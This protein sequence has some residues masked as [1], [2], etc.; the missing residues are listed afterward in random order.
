D[1]W[2]LR[3]L[4]IE[5]IE[6]DNLK[7]LTLGPF[8]IDAF[9]I[10]H[11][12]PDAVGLVIQT[13]VGQIVHLCDFKIDFQ[14]VA[15]KPA[16]LGRLVELTSKGTVLLMSDST[17][18]EMPGHTPSE[19]VIMKNLEEI[20]HNAPARI[21]VGTFASLLER[22]QQ[23]V[24][25][26]EEHDRKV[27]VE[28]Y[29][30]R[31]N[32]AIAQQLGYLKAK[33]GTI[34]TA[35][36]AGR[37]PANKLVILCTGAQ[38]EDRAVLMRIANK[39]HKHFRVDTGDTVI[40][41]SSIVPGNERAV[42][43]LKDSFYRQGAKV[44]HYKMMDIHASGHAHQE[45]LKLMINLVRP[46]YFMPIH[47]FHSMLRANQELA[48]EVG[49]PKENVI[50]ASNGGVV[51]VTTGKV[52]LAPQRVPAGYVMVD[53]LGIGDIGEVVLRDRQVM[54]QDGMVVIIG[55]IDTQ[56]GAL[57][58]EPDIISRGF[59][60][61]RESK[62]LVNEMKKRARFI[63]ERS[64]H[65]QRDINDLYIKN[66]LRDELGEF[67]FQKTKRRPMILPVLITV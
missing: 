31:S 64:I 29:S 25:I 16:D 6:K 59:V 63:I 23:I 35:E 47:G 13:P 1:F 8:A 49:I 32:V 39:E 9:H 58:G 7:T 46:K 65:G 66:N 26:A 38:G 12:I 20:F 3:K 11:N 55:I 4:H 41:S 50:I 27:V 57:K 43:G 24:W 5:T 34:I 15:D 28:G 33:K 18:A 48:M 37:L 51:E 42:Q 53:G 40:F 52:R 14:P 61:M 2:H 67:L 17:G 30:M 44:F 21:I 22:V 56:R 45:E 19:Q 54:A 60:Y 10:N 36:Q 62:E